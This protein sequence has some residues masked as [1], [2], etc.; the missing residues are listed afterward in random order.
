[1]NDK[2][3]CAYLNDAIKSYVV[4]MNFIIIGIL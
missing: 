2:V 4:I 3:F 1:M